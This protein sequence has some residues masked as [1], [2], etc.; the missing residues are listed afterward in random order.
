MVREF[1]SIQ[2]LSTIA[3]LLEFAPGSVGALYQLYD[4]IGPEMPSD[5]K[6]TAAKTSVNGLPA[7]YFNYDEGHAGRFSV[8]DTKGASVAFDWVMRR[9]E[10]SQYIL[11]YLTFRD[12]TITASATATATTAATTAAATATTFTTEGKKAEVA[13]GAKE[14]DDAK[15]AKEAEDADDADDAKDEEGGSEELAVFIP[16][17]NTLHEEKEGETSTVQRLKHY[18]KVTNKPMSQL[19]IGT[20]FDQGN[21]GIKPGPGKLIQAIFDNPLIPDSLKFT[22]QGESLEWNA[23]QIDSLQAALSKVNLIETPIKTSIKGLLDNAFTSSENLEPVTIIAYSRGT[24]EVEAALKTFIEKKIEEGMKLEKVEERLRERVTIVTI[25]SA[26]ADFPSGPA[27]LHVAAWTDPLAS[28][29]GV[30]RGHN[31]SEEKAGKDAVF[32]NCSSPYNSEAFDNHNY[33]AVTSQFISVILSLNN[34][35]H[36]RDLWNLGFSNKLIVP[37]DVDDLTNA[38]IQ[39]SRGYEW[40]WTPEA[41]WKDVQFGALPS[42]EDAENLLT[43]RL[44]NAYV[45]HMKKTF[46]K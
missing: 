13:D 19:H 38:V 14:A 22:R 21:V 31:D 45:N 33:G 36:F 18:I 42:N 23:R 9:P 11:K 32:L 24:I 4:A 39:L 20:S 10:P 5:L 43:K 25:G 8:P 41:A 35:D 34:V 15:Y 26:T 12:G 46:A 28:T 7:L 37:D 3:P 2:S 16:G 1:D 30:M 27:Y 29:S 44:G 40:L 17:L 6:S